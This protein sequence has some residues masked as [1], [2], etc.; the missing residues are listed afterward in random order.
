[1]HPATSL[2]AGAIAFR[3]E[4]MITVALLAVVVLHRRGR[5][6]GAAVALLA[7]ALTKETALVLGPLMIAALELEPRLRARPRPWRLLAAEGGALVAAV[8]LRLAFA[9]AWR[10]GF[11]PLN[12]G[13]A[14]GTRLASVMKS[15]LFSWSRWIA[16]SATPSR[17]RGRAA[18]GRWV[19]RWSGGARGPGVAAAG[20]GA[21]PAAVAAAV[22]AAG[23]DHALV[24]A[25]LPISAARLCGDAGRRGG[26][27]ARA[28][29]GGGGGG[30]GGRFAIV[31]LVD[32]RRF[33]SDEALWT[34]EVAAN[35]ACREGH[36][37]LGVAA[38]EG[39]RLDV[40]AEHLER[41]TGETEGVLSY[42][43]RGPAL[44]NLGVVRLQQQ[45]LPQARV[46]LGAALALVAEERAHRRIAHNLATVE[47]RAGNAAEAARLLEPE[48]ARTDAFPESIFVR[49]RALHQLGREA[50]AGALVH[51]LRSR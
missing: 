21:A 24:V 51:R 17:S 34:P 37:Y 26:G 50:E 18:R 27:G 8:A 19:G 12:P 10:A 35:P 42:V 31:A 39:K 36:F 4:A 7:G 3:S 30:G 40:A 43:D 16:R 25:A 49:A 45:Q 28:A 2:V 47:L 29:R 5:P 6:L 41:A 38:L 15:A 46:A 14:I 23:A 20:P 22:A 1:M 13:A 9:P 48:V 11:A 32:G 44:Q 33:R